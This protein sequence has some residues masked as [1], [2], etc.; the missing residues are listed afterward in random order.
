[1]RKFTI[2]NEISTLRNA[3]KL[4]PPNIRELINRGRILQDKKKRFIEERRNILFNFSLSHNDLKREETLLQN[5]FQIYYIGE[6]KE[7]SQTSRV[8]NVVV[9]LKFDKNIINLEN[10]KKYFKYGKYDII[11]KG[12]KCFKNNVES[13]ELRVALPSLEFDSVKDSFEKTLNAKCLSLKIDNIGYYH[14]LPLESMK[15]MLDNVPRK[16]IPL[17]LNMNL[18]L[19]TTSEKLHIFPGY[20]GKNFRGVFFYPNILFIHSKSLEEFKMNVKKLKNL[21]YNLTIKMFRNLKLSN[22]EIN[23]I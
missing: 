22:V 20:P 6:E 14:V 13:N 4:R 7:R 15:D 1:M 3:S 2:D 11:I 19:Q 17:S 21:D 16:D 18:S 9:I 12:F 23:N 8:S 10:F 5:K